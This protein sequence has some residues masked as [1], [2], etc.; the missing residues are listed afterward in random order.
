[1]RL[2]SSLKL[3]AMLRVEPDGDGA[4]ITYSM[5]MA[6]WGK[7]GRLGEAIFR[8]RTAEVE[9]QFVAAFTQAC[10]GKTVAAEV[11]TPEP[12]AVSAAA[13]HLTDPA[14][15]EA[16]NRGPTTVTESPAGTMPSS[17]LAQAVRGSVWQRA[18]A[19]LRRLFTRGGR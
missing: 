1:M 7:L 14:V 3:N 12:E 13:T 11:M 16:A 8:R 9:Q 2:G 19:A 4:E 10:T 17:P 6:L 5:E 15:P 18:M